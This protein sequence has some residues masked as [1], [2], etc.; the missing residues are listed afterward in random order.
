MGKRKRVELRVMSNVKDVVTEPVRCKK[1]KLSYFYVN[2]I[3]M[4]FL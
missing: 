3:K 4:S 2:S 1:K